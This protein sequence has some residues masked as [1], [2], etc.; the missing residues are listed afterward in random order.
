MQIHCNSREPAQR[1]MWQKNANKAELPSLYIG[2]EI[3]GD[4]GIIEMCYE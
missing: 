3:A 4:P 2:F 1:R